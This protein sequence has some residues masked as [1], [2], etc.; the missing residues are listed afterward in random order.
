MSNVDQIREEIYLS[1]SAYDEVQLADL[2]KVWRRGDFWCPQVCRRLRDERI[3]HGINLGESAF[4][5]SR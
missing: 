2:E 4:A 3:T 5:A 1:S